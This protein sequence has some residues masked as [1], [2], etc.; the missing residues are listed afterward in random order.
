VREKMRVRRSDTPSNPRPSAKLVKLPPIFALAPRERL[1]KHHHV[2]SNRPHNV[3]LLLAPRM[4]PSTCPVIRALCE[5]VRTSP[6]HGRYI[7]RLAEDNEVPIHRAIDRTA[8]RE[9]RVALMVSSSRL[10][11]VPLRNSV[12]EAPDGT[13]STVQNPRRPA[14]APNRAGS[15]DGRTWLLVRQRHHRQYLEECNHGLPSFPHCALKNQQ[16]SR[17]DPPNPAFSNW[18]CQGWIYCV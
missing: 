9:I 12:A 13:A 3:R 2:F 14:P 18:V 11:A 16:A 4:F 15:A 5:K 7:Q 17:F 10:Y 6:S 1:I 8:L